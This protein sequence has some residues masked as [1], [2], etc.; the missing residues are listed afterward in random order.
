[1]SEVHDMRLHDILDI[2]GYHIIAVP[3]GWIYTYHRLD[4]GQMN[5]VFVPYDN[6]VKYRVT[7]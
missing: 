4:S 2:G 1:M 7:Q 3:S 5:S 6:G